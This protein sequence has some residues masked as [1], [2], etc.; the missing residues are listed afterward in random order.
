M[1]GRKTEGFFSSGLSHLAGPSAPT[2]MAMPDTADAE[3]DGASL[4]YSA[5]FGS[6][7][8]APELEEDAAPEEDTVEG[9]LVSAFGKIFVKGKE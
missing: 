8:A 3:Y 7:G 1:E 6:A 5:Y 4:A 2:A 9:K